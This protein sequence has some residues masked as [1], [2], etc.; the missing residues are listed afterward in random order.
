[1]ALW[2]SGDTFWD[3]DLSR[4]EAVMT[5]VSDPLGIAV[6]NRPMSANTWLNENL[7]PDDRASVEQGIRD[8]ASGAQDQFES[9]HRVRNRAGRW[10]WVFVRGKIV[11][12]DDAGQPVR[13]CGTARDITISR[14]AERERRIAA[15]VI[16]SMTEAVCVTD[17]DFNFVS[18]N[19]AFTR[20]TR[21][22]EAEVV[23]QPASLLNCSKHTPQHYQKMREDFLRH[24]HWRGELW[25]KR[26]DGMEFMCW[27]EISVVNDA[28]GD[29][30]HFVGV[31][32]DITERK[33]TEQELLY[34]ANYDPL[35]GLPNRTLLVERL[36]QAVIRARRA[37]PRKVALLFLDLDRFKHVNDSM[38]HAT[39][40]RMLKAAGVRL[41]AS[42]RDSDTVA[43]L[44]GDEF[45]VVLE[46]LQLVREAEEIAQKLLD[47]FSV[48][49]Q[50]D[51]GEEVVISPSIGI[52]LYPDHGQMPTE[53]LKSAD[54]AMYQA[55]E[56]GRNTYMVYTREMDT[57]ARSR[58]NMIA[59]LHKGLERNELSLVYQPKLSLLDKRI[60]GVEALLR[61]RS[62]ELGNV[63]P[64]TFIPLAEETGLIVKIGEFVLNTACAQLRRWH[65]LGQTEIAMAVNLSMLQ[66]L[67]G[68]LTLHLSEIL[69]TH[70]LRPERLEMELTES[71]VMAN[72]EQ[73]VRTL[74]ELKAIGVSLAIDDFGTGY[75]S[76]AYLKR[77]PIDALKIDQTF[78]GDLT[79]DPDDEAI[80]ATIIRMAHS[81]GLNVV[82]EGVETVEQLEYLREQGC[83]EIQG[84]WFSPPLEADACYTFLESFARSQAAGDRQP[85]R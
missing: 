37:L 21:Y 75:S 36:G 80:T 66:L 11:E 22:E 32:S 12:R 65:D 67:R 40:D 34:L 50:L 4:D 33:R 47:E 83:D 5:G 28:A 62:E 84:Y 9:E 46:D 69:K 35:T 49:L 43:R 64:A 68:E 77:L 27:V 42:V 70:G 61:W 15:E 26:K 52:S 71:M 18:V 63:P 82:A 56:R 6:D 16:D 58:A 39:G 60:T 57:A 81:L 45:T 3:W 24:G 48:P 13:I 14:E 17:L 25:Q 55:K 54:T 44:G 8:H 10:V 51:S 78:V 76:L 1:M 29:R 72:A 2:G 23:G 20:M 79:I 30:T 7:H 73:S 19:R 74:T 53:L 85:T 38:G 41:R 31:M 59:A